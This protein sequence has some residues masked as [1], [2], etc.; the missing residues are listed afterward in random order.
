MK[1]LWIASITSTIILSAM[2]GAVF[3]LSPLLDGRASDADTSTEN[4]LG[5]NDYH[6][7]N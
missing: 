3:L 5:R 6:D 2:S 4:L 1:I 7:I